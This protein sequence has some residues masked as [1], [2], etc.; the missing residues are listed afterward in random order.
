MTPDY[1]ALELARAQRTALNGLFR[2]QMTRE[3]T[4]DPFHQM[5]GRARNDLARE[6]E[7]LEDYKRELVENQSNMPMKPL[8]RT[9]L[10]ND[11]LQELLDDPNVVRLRA[12][13][14]ERIPD[15]KDDYTFADDVV[16]EVVLVSVELGSLH[17]AYL[18][19]AGMGL[20]NC[21]ADEDRLSVM[22]TN[23]FNAMPSWENHGWSPQELYEQ[24]TGRK[25]FY[26]DDGSPMKIGADD[27]CP[28]NSGKKYRDCCGR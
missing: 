21:C 6:L 7:R 22:V 3:F 9:L 2:E 14:D 25:L 19:A 16:R 8:S 5:M 17:E 23:A 26:N 15:G 11:P 24:V 12:F 13:I 28:C 1:V 10:E 20:E 4:P 18:T 27:P